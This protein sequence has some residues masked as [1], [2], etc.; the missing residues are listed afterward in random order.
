MTLSAKEAV[1]RRYPNP[2]PGDG[3]YHPKYDWDAPPVS[4]EELAGLMEALSPAIEVARDMQYEYALR[5]LV[6][7]GDRLLSDSKMIAE[8]HIIPKL[9]RVGG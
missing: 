6:T 7:L 5:A 9:K 4:A 8:G 3:F 1:Q 2:I